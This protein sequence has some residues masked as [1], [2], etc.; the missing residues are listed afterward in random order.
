[1]KS[2]RQTRGYTN[3]QLDSSTR[4][5]L[6]IL[7]PCWSKFAIFLPS[8]C[9]K[10]ELPKDKQEICKAT[11]KENEI[12]YFILISFCLSDRRSIFMNEIMYMMCGMFNITLQQIILEKLI[13]GLNLPFKMNTP[14]YSEIMFG[15]VLTY[16]Y[17]NLNKVILSTSR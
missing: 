1:M 7:Y 3:L 4:C 10:G 5:G 12:I 2:P 15:E 8:I 14:T 16:G 9:G 17:K 6:G 11:S 13:Q